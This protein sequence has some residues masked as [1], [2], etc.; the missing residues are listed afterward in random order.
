MKRFFQKYKKIVL[1]ISVFLV[2]LTGSIIYGLT[3]LEKTV[4]V[5]S[6]MFL[7]D[8]IQIEKIDVQKDK[9]RL[10]GISMSLDGVPFI[11]IPEVRAERLSFASLGEISIPEADVY[12]RRSQEGMF[13]IDRFIPKDKKEKKKID[14]KD[15]KPVIGV[16]IGKI[17]FPNV[18]VHYEDEA[19]NPIF[20]KMITFQGEV[21]FDKERGISAQIDG[22][23]EKERYK[24]KYSGEK[25]PYDVYLDVVGVDLNSYLKPYLTSDS[26]KIEA[27]KVEAHLHFNYYGNFGEVKAE[28]PTLE[29]ANKK[30]KDAEAY[31]L[32][33][34][35]EIQVALDYEEDTKN[36]AALL[37][38]DLEKEEAHIE[39]MDFYYDKIILDLEKKKNWKL[40]FL[41]ESK[42]YPKLTGTFDW[43]NTNKEFSFALNSNI[44]K[45]KGMYAKE[46]K[47]IK[48][49]EKNQFSLLYDIEKQN[50]REGK[51]KIPFHVYDY[52]G[53]INFE[54]KDNQVKLS[55]LK[56]F[57]KD[58]GNIEAK[59]NLDITNKKLALKYNTDHFTWSQKISGNDLLIKLA[60]KGEVNY[61]EKEGLQ[62]S[63]RGEIEKIQFGKY[64][65]E[66]LRADV[67]YKDNNLNV[68]ALENRYL[69]AEGNLDFKSKN[70]N[71][72]IEVTDLDNDSL[73][74]EYPKFKIKKANALIEGNISN[75]LVKISLNES[76]IFLLKEKE[77]KVKG[78]FFIE[79]KVLHFNNVQIDQNRA[80][81]KY[82]IADGSYDVTANIIEE[83]L[84]DYY[85]FH[86]LYYRVIGEVLVQGKGRELEAKVTSTLD[87]IYYQG[88][89]LPDIS[90]AGKY[91]LGKEGIGEFEFSKVNVQ[92]Q[93]GK[94]LLSLTGNV[95][96][97][98][99]AVNVDIEKQDLSFEDIQEYTQLDVMKG[100]L[101]I[102]GNVRGIYKK[103]K[104]Q[105]KIEGREL[106][107]NSSPLDCF[108]VDIQGNEEKINVNKIETAYKKNKLEIT[109]YYGI[110][111]GNYDISVHSPDIDWSALQDL[112]SEYGVKNL[113]GK[114]DLDMHLR[115]VN[116]S[117]KFQIKNLSFSIPE[118]YVDVKNLEGNINFLGKEMLIEKIQGKVNDGQVSLEGRV[119]L[120]EL[121]KIGKD[122]SFLQ[123]L[124]YVLNLNVDELKYRIPDVL[125]LDISSNLRLEEN[126]MRGN[127]EIIRGLVQDVPNAYQSYWKILRDFFSKKT[128][129]TVAPAEVV[130]ENKEAPD[131]MIT[132][133]LESLLDMDV[134]L[135]IREG[136]RLNIPA[137]N[138]A[139]EEVQG[140]ITG[141]LTL[142]GKQGKYAV[143]GNIE[144]EQGSLMVNTNT[145]VL[146]K[147][148]VS[149]NDA[150]AYLPN[151]QPSVLVDS[152]VEVNADRV[153]FSIQG[154][155]SELRFT[156]SSKTGST[157]GSLNSLLTGD[158]Q[159]NGEND[160][161][162]AL[163]QN[164]IGGQLTQTVIGPVTRWI[165]KAF[166]VERFRV[167]SNIYNQSSARRDTSEGNLAVG[168][169]MEV[170]DNIYKDRLYWNF[171]GNLYDS[172]GQSTQGRSK[173]NRVMDEYDFSIQ[174]PYS[175]TKTFEIGVG[176]LPSKFYT[177]DEQRENRKLNYHIG[178]K[179]EKKM[180]DFFD[181][182][183]E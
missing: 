87:K 32:L 92:N 3:H 131:N 63:S 16:P 58:R 113:S 105:L 34:G 65:I 52:T 106:K 95:N 10:L 179:I 123:D 165:R 125:S 169:K 126:K 170:R 181:I 91:T 176:K 150:K 39:L 73:K 49:Y 142:A 54:A 120:P 139:V 135:F 158:V 70:S 90:L 2:I 61:T 98:S 85:G 86:D 108:T 143:L 45:T 101:S 50:L 119:E 161:Y 74:L 76:S 36:K 156:I 29:F 137:L 178:V 112:V 109:G 77:N 104:Y 5:L 57:N 110:S 162:I 13:N 160:T 14:L 28:I 180:D 127:I 60:L 81:G 155:L 79:N 100:I 103:P 177:T 23:D 51:G 55:S 133:Q 69:Y 11:Q 168:A 167:T 47:T 94:K 59:G 15:Y 129:T 99:Q 147:A 182:F 40:S 4:A 134:S 41:A 33:E 72:K 25:M 171:T 71:L 114:S 20:K 80:F 141:G 152:T 146:D 12:L 37:F 22:K 9:I 56:I 136:I 27:G 82:N 88:K 164:L 6:K 132:M 159:G 97:D 78:E 53:G 130:G 163:L 102:E 21:V 149:F 62:A 93:K 48:L 157:S 121:N 174:Y 66:G 43:E 145:F 42:I 148:I 96:L 46:E 154:K 17:M 173:D 18:R 183:K 38:Y 44:I 107:V 138:V 122:L 172:G 75:P 124:S 151:V 111:S 175:K 116:S 68:Y 153:R 144:V 83:K 89:K 118:K 84:S 115:N 117:G 64:G 31:V 35:Q 67:E 30:W 1:G 128:A 26:V 24:L 7:G 19:L 8:P 140:N 166:H